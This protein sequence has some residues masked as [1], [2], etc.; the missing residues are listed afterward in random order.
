[1]DCELALLESFIARKLTISRSPGLLKDV[2][3]LL[4]HALGDER[5]PFK[6]ADALLA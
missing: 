6:F 1:M 4:R 3:T 2:S 5:R